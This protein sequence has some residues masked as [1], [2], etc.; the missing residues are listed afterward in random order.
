MKRMAK[1]DWYY[2]YPDDQHAMLNGKI[3]IDWIKNQLKQ[4]SIR[5]EGLE[6]ANQLWDSYASPNSLVKPDFLAKKTQQEMAKEMDEKEKMVTPEA[7]Q[8]KTSRSG[9]CSLRKILL[10]TR[11]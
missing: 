4:I 9:N 2:E 3:K 8:G 10:T 1:A 11:G 5:R 6:A 7:L